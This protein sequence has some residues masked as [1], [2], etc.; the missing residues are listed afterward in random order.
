MAKCQMKKG[1]FYLRECE[2]QSVSTCTV[3]GREFCQEHMKMLPGKNQPACLDCLGKEMQRAKS[4]KARNDYYEDDYYFD[5]VWSYGY[6]HSYYRNN[7]YSPWYDNSSLDDDYYSEFDV[8][9]FDDRAEAGENQLLAED[10]DDEANVFD[11]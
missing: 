10:Y 4:D 3:C 1:F 8:R 7:R 6:R 11:S 9:S 5:P 2:K